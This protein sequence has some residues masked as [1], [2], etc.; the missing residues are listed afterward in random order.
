MPIKTFQNSFRY[1][2]NL[3]LRDFSENPR[4]DSANV[5]K[6]LPYVDVQTGIKNRVLAC[7]PITGLGELSPELD[8]LKGSNIQRKKMVQRNPILLDEHSEEYDC[9]YTTKHVIRKQRIIRDPI[10]LNGD[11]GEE[12]DHLRPHGGRSRNKAAN[13][14]PKRDPIAGVGDFGREWDP[15]YKYDGRPNLHRPV[16]EK[17]DPITHSTH[18]EA[19]CAREMRHFPEKQGGLDITGH[20]DVNVALEKG[21]GR[22]IFPEKIQRTDHLSHDCTIAWKPKDGGTRPAE[23]NTTDSIQCNRN[24]ITHYNC[25][26]AVATTGLRLELCPEEPLPLRTARRPLTSEFTRHRN[27]ITGVGMREEDY[28]TA[29]NV[30]LGF[31]IRRTSTRKPKTPK[32]T[33]TENAKAIRPAKKPAAETK[34]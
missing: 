27:P 32:P 8:V 17:T 31:W 13:K 26:Y 19:N 11:L 28:F 15:I 22:K 12:L 16:Q 34:S 30:P 33:K 29:I 5:A 24:P 14:D 21:R 23:V 20:T 2:H 7:D 18:P 9:L 6:L 4:N 1:P 25:V 3:V 10:T